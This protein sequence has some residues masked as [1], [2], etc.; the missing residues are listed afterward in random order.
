MDLCALEE[1][2]KAKEGK[3]KLVYTVPVHHNPVGVTMSNAKREKLVSLA[4]QYKFYVLADEAYQ[5]LNFE[6]TGVL[7][8]FYYD[9]PADPKVLSVGTFSKLIGP[10][11]KVGWVQAHEPLLK[12]LASLGYIDSGNNPVIFSSCNL[13]DFLESGACDRHIAMISKVIGGKCKLMVKKLKEVGLEPND[14]KGGYF[15][16]VKSKGKTTGKTG[17]PMAIKKD[18]FHDMMRLEPNEPK[19]G[20]F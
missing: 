8:M 9:D 2:V 6:P 7:P 10:G 12:P 18:K 16:W 5:L 19:G 11:T 17:E 15:V 4:R 3:I 20:Y 13:I 1:L 14:P